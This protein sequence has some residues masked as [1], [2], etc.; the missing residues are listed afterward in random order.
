VNAPLPCLSTTIAKRNEK[1]KEKEKEKETNIAHPKL[2][3][4]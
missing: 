1:E 2:Y 4:I 3:Y